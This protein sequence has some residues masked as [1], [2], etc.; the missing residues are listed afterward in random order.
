MM[1]LMCKILNKESVVVDSIV[2]TKASNDISL[3]GRNQKQLKQIKYWT[4]IC[5]LQLQINYIGA[6]CLLDVLKATVC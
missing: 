1:S 2:A 3:G 5:Q 6:P 4:Y